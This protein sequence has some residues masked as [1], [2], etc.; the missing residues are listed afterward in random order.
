MRFTKIL[1][2]TD[3]S[4]GSQQA[5][6]VAVRMASEANAELVVVH[7]WYMPPSAFAGESMFPA[8]LIQSM[9]DDSRRGLDAAV[10]DAA[11]AGAKHVSGKLLT[12]GPGAEIVGCLEKDAFDLCVIGTQGRSGLARI[13]LGSVAEK[14]VRHSP[15]SVLAVHPDG[16]AKPFSH[17]LVP[18]DFSESAEHALD[19][20]AQLV[21]P[22]GAITL[23]HVIELP[24]GYVGEPLAA[25]FARDLDKHSRAALDK[26]VSRLTSKVAVPVA[27]SSRIGRPGVQTLAAL[28]Q[29]RSID[30][31]VMGS[32]GRTGIRRAVLGSVAEKVVRHARCPVL[33]VRTRSTTASAAHIAHS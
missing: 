31:V 9:I 24:F 1:C 27:T 13:L 33:V 4:P 2:P 29:D 7:A 32:R 5:L 21:L 25:D 18:T 8:E 30:L 15:C 26:A 23:L 19:L 10:R 16:G 22:D 14:V 12:G 28:D 3:F 6:R 11:A 20:A 17:V